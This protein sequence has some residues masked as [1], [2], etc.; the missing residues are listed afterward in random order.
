MM[1]VGLIFASKKLIVKLMLLN[2]LCG[3]TVWH[4]TAFLLAC[5][6]SEAQSVDKAHNWIGKVFC[7][8]LAVVS[9]PHSAIQCPQAFRY[10]ANSRPFKPDLYQTSNFITEHKMSYSPK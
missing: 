6:L 10:L 7:C 8:G 1:Y 3:R 5:N 4:L 2:G 9:E